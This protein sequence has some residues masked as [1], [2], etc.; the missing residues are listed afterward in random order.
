M[1]ENIK[2]FINHKDW[3]ENI[4]IN[5]KKHELYRES[6]PENKMNDFYIN[7]HFLKINW[8]EW[9]IDYFFS[10]NE[11]D[12][13]Q[14]HHSFYYHF[15]QYYSYYFIIKKDSQTLLLGNPELGICYDVNQ[16]SLYYYFK[17]KDQ[18]FILLNDEKQEEFIFILK[19][20]QYIEQSLFYSNYKKIMI[21]FNNTNES[22]IIDLKSHVFYLEYHP[23]IKG[24]CILYHDVLFLKTLFQH[25]FFK[26]INNIYQQFDIKTIES[27]ISYV[28]NS[29]FNSVQDNSYIFILNNLDKTVLPLI[30]YL[31]QY[32]YNIV[33]LTHSKYIEQQKIY[34]D[35]Q[36]FYYESHQLNTIIESLYQLNQPFYYYSHYKE[37]FKQGISLH[38]FQDFDFDHYNQF[39][40]KDF[41]YLIDTQLNNILLNQSFD[42][43][44][45]HISLLKP[46]KKIHYFKNSKIPKILHFIWLGDQ[47]Y[48]PHYLFFLQSWFQNY[49]DFIF[50]FWN[51]TN[52]IPLFNQY[53]FD[54]SL[55]QA[56]KA[57]ICRYEI[58]YQYGG[59]Y[60]DADV[61]SIKNLEEIIENIDGFSG[62]ES[63]DF[64]AIGLMGFSKNN[65][66][67]KQI[68]LFLAF[69][70]ALYSNTKIPYQTGPVFFTTM[71]NC[72]I[73][74]SSSKYKAFKKEYFYD[75][76]YKDK[77]NKKSIVFKKN[78]YCYHSWGYS[79][80]PDHYQKN[81]MLFYYPLYFLFHHQIQLHSLKQHH[82]NNCL[83][84]YHSF[85]DIS[86]YLKKYIFY[87]TNNNNL[88]N[89]KIKVVHVMGH[90]F[91]GGIERYL[92]YLEK[93]G[94]HELF[95]YYLL[96]YHP[97][98][99]NFKNEINYFKHIHHF[100]FK[101]N[102]NLKHYLNLIS[103][104]Y[105]IDHYSQYIDVFLYTNDI[106]LNQVIHF[107]HSS[108]NY[109]KDISSLNIHQCIHLYNE[110]NKHK[111]WLPIQHNYYLTLGT[112][113][114]EDS[115]INNVFHMK[116]I[117]KNK[118]KKIKL[119][120]I[121]RIVQEKLPI[122]FFK[123][124]CELSNTLDHID[125]HI[126]GQKA[127]CFD[128]TSQYNNLFDS[129][130]KNST[131]HYEGYIPFEK[132]NEIYEHIDV[133]LIPSLFE[134]GSFTCLEAFSY[135]IP[136]I[137]L[138][139]FGLKYLIKNNILGYLCEDYD[140][141]LN[142]I[143]YLYYDQ[144]LDH[145]SLIYDHS[146]NYNIQHKINDFEN[147]ISSQYHKKYDNIII[148]TSVLNIIKKPLSYYHTRS[149]FN[150]HERYEQTKKTIASIKKYIPDVK[151]IC[152]ECSHM[153]YYQEYENEI[154]SS[155]D[156]YLNCYSNEK[157][158]NAVQSEHKGYG[159]V[160]LVLKAIDYL[161]KHQ[162]ECHHLFKISGRYFLNELFNYSDF[163]SKH[164]CFTLWDHS[165]ES[166]C[167]LFY[168]IDGRF[169]N[170]YENCLNQMI[171]K[172]QKGNCLEMELYQMITSIFQFQ[173][174]KIIPKINISGYLS[175]EGYIFH[176]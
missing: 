47:Q 169:I 105:I 151:I 134:T 18:Q 52:L 101:N 113:I 92:L 146:L 41:K 77:Q 127:D 118:F 19:Q 93:Y 57:D 33:I 161:K 49:P 82:F 103:P 154:K 145:S 69:N 107:I 50:C 83:Q 45:T 37:S 139:N 3:Q 22:V 164:H 27:S 76:S 61:Y 99:F 60:V 176:L 100:Y 73:D 162:I 122:D 84:K 94:N 95:N 174:I 39:N 165:F 44:N 78:N 10:I 25:L 6:E 11:T 116:N 158:K 1:N 141:I 59:I 24:E 155:V 166:Y 96:S 121:G 17:T 38:C 119:G 36:C 2:I 143:K 149:V 138:N 115:I 70:Y 133:L 4:I 111:S 58:L 98:D 120:I 132:S 106:Y 142:K 75:Y 163:N 170:V 114:V 21:E 74:K 153:E 128:K 112:E 110:K 117:R 147:I 81:N 80:N 23:Q 168:K 159:E 13:F 32:H 123:K 135:G 125:I 28:D 67:L 137:A 90:F 157:I 72:L 87:H 46:Q 175:T 5:H 62:Y 148:I 55:T 109:N 26:K 15:S 35:I 71:W 89:K 16:P 30:H 42:T 136:V 167:S 56:Q 53:S 150:I 88:K 12:Y 34:Y 85:I 65:I 51:D 20:N 97:Q 40:I 129:Y 172:L 7:P 152:I 86:N 29:L 124:L 64:I 68:I 8:K 43:F 126:Y 9:G 31:N 63:E 131:I 108:I 171:K 48:H 54:N 156:Y 140:E 173:Y 102:Y 79:W 160:M 91:V 66:F 144:I 104:D 130:L 14:H